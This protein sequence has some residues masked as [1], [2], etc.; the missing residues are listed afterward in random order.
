MFSWT[1][2]SSL[3]CRHGRH[4]AWKRTGSCLLLPS[5]GSAAEASISL[6]MTSIVGTLSSLLKCP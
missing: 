2:K 4:C 3:C 1:A 5:A 6:A